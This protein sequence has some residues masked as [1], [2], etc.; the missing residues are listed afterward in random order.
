VL[1]AGDA[2]GC[3]EWAAVNAIDAGD[4]AAE[5]KPPVWGEDDRRLEAGLPAE[6]DPWPSKGVEVA[7]ADPDAAAEIVTG[8]D[9]AE[10]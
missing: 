8:V 7:D 4:V 6:S 9:D 3:E 10:G 1:C 2:Y 5:A